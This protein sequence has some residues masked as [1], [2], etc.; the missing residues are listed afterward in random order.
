MARKERSS[1]FLVGHPDYQDVWVEAADW[2]LATVEAAKIWGVP[3]KEVAFYCV[4]RRRQDKLGGVCPRCGR[5]FNSGGMLL[6]DGCRKAQE[7]EAAEDQRRAKRYWQKES[8]R[9]SKRKRQEEDP[10]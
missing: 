1:V 9:L 4:Q 7:T 2:P 8:E 6:C 3:W 5:F 10:S